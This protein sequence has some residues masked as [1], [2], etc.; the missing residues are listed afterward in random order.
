[1]AERWQAASRLPLSP[2]WQPATCNINRIWALNAAILMPFYI[3]LELN[4]TGCRHDTIFAY[5]HDIM[6]VTDFKADGKNNFFE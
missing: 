3:R 6:P 4:A 1:V 2:G 5:L